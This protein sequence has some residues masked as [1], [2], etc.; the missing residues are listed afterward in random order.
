MALRTSLIL[1]SFALMLSSQTRTA[2]AQLAPGAYDRTLAYDGIERLYS[3]YV[4]T[5]Y[6][7]T[8][9]VP[10]VLDFHGYLSNKG[11]QYG[12]SGFKAVSDLEGFI[13]VYPQG[14]FGNPENPTG[15]N[16]PHGPSWNSGDLC[17]GDAIVQDPDDVGFARAVV[18]AVA[19]EANI[20]L[21]RTYVTGLSNGGAISQRISCEAADAFAASAPFAFPIGFDPLSQCQPSRPFPT[22]AFAGVTD[23]LV[24]YEGGDIGADNN[25][26]LA[27][28]QQSFAHWR[29]VNGCVSA[30]PDTTTQPGPTSTCEQY[31]NCDDGVEVGLCSVTGVAN[32]LG[33]VLYANEDSLNLAQ[34][35]WDFMSQYSLPSACLALPISGCKEG[36]KAVLSVRGPGDSTASGRNAGGSAAGRSGPSDCPGC[37][38]K[39]KLA[40]GDDTSLVSL[41]DP[42]STTQ[43]ALCLHDSRSQV[44]LLQSTI[45]VGPGSE[46]V[47][48]GDKGYKFTDSSGQKGGATSIILRAGDAGRAKIAVKAGGT[49]LD[50]P[51]SASADQLLAADGEVT[52]QLISSEGECWSSTFTSTRKSSATKFKAKTP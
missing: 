37:Q 44:P 39:W 41:G 29:D 4:P 5:A 31:T 43:Y 13:V 33:H 25:A 30:S 16:N 45:I 42:R 10:L 21:R 23:Q 38:I 52:I 14:L 36:G 48:T 32:G 22:L 28:A 2:D 8:T 20:D 51:K 46:W 50:A 40:K 15:S 27:S 3:I 1:I 18:S 26:I 11:Q 35:A 19:L 24:P 7:G 17:C 47:A 34:M 49:Q 6:D 9:A 12:I